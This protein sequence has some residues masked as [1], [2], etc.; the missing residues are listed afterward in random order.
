M[1]AL[2]PFKV[3]NHISEHGRS[4]LE[5]ECP[6]CNSEFEAYIWSLSGSGKKCPKCKT[7]HYRNGAHPERAQR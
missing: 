4:R 1:A 3:L 7:L 6:H 5:I 2:I